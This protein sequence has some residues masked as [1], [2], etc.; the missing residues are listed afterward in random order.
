M[1]TV[2]VT[3][4]P[5]VRR[6]RSVKMGW[7]DLFRASTRRSKTGV[8]QED[9]R[10]L[11]ATVSQV[12]ARVSNLDAQLGTIHLTL[13]KHD[14]EI[15]ECRDL[16]GQ[17]IHKVGG[18]IQLRFENPEGLND[19]TISVEVSADNSTYAATTAANNL[20]AITNVS[21]PRK[22]FNDYELLLRQGVDLYMRVRGS[23]RTRVQMQ[24]RTGG[25]LDIEDLSN[26]APTA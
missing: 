21:I 16:T 24:V 10:R 14:D 2:S 8:S 18:V 15:A 9:H 4:I 11:V 13:H 6:P 19:A 23:G 7:F 26:A 5:E 1:A 17:H 22:T 25:F 12:K 20:E 3:T